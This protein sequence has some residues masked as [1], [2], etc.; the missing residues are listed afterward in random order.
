MKQYISGIVALVMAAFML[1]SCQEDT[2]TYDGP[3]HVMFEDS[4][5]VIAITNSTDWHDIMIGTTRAADHD[6]NYGIEVVAKGTNAIEGE[7]FTLESPTVTIK[8]GERAA[9]VRI[10]GDFDKISDTDSIGVTLRLVNKDQTWNLY[11]DETKVT[12]QKVCP[13]DI[14][15]FNT[16]Y[17]RVTSQYFTDYMKP[18]TER[19]IK[20]E[21]DTAANTLV[22][23]NFFYNGR[24]VKIRF[25]TDDVLE[26][27]I[28]AEDGQILGTTAE[29]FG[30]QYGDTYVRMDL[31]PTYTSF[32]NVCQHYAILYT[33]IYV[34]GRGTVGTYLT[35]L[36]W[37]SKEEAEVNGVK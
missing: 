8:A 4:T 14:D 16:G 17:C 11:G 31:A 21:K 28:E 12:L 24:D 29:A 26:P 22:L 3:D 9:A 2:I 19:I 18:V 37:I 5:Q 10:K 23:K 1:A 25:N 32:Y 27:L 33:T 6:R 36:E 20:V 7:Q 34:T 30:T 15:A 13:F 35:V